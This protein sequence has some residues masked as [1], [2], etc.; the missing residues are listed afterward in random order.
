MTFQKIV[1]NNMETLIIAGLGNPGKSYALTRHNIGFMFFDYIAQNDCIESF[2]ISKKLNSALSENRSGSQ[3][4][5]FTK[6]LT[7]MNNSGLST[8]SVIR[9]YKTTPEKLIVIHDDLDIEFGKYKISK[10]KNA[11]GHNGILSI[12]NNIG[13]KNFVRI[14]IGIDNRTKEQRINQSGA[15]YVLSRFTTKELKELPY[16]FNQILSN[17]IFKSYIQ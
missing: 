17:E 7:F 5:V 3:K 13:T 9:F 8:N 12:I 1:N 4:Y 14:R 6:P 10:N 11:S 2:K 16:I 15:D